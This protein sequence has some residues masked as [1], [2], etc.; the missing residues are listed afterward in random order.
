[1]DAQQL[2]PGLWRWTA[3]HDRWKKDVGCVYAETEDSLVLIDPLVPGD[4]GDRFWAALDRDVKR[5]GLPV[6]VL[7]TIFF[8]ARSAGAVAERYGGRLWVEKRA[9]RRIANR[10][11]EATDTFEVDDQLPG[12]MRAFDANRAAEVVYWLPEHRSLVVGDVMLG[13]PF[14]LC[15]KSWLERGVGHDSLK[16]ALRPLLE[17]PVERVLVSHGEPV[18]ENG[19]AELVR[20]LG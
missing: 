9:R 11:G 15:P 7:V 14:R 18:L 20:L 19:H 2:A 13:S 5:V 10:G 16:A 8:H 17:L 6:H 1:M 12:G 4:D 3:Y